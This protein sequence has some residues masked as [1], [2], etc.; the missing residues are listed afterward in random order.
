MEP[1]GLTKK[2]WYYAKMSREE[3]EKFLSGLTGL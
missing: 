2:P 3:A 1:E